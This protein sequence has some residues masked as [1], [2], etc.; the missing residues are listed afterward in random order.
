M[1]TT[2]QQVA[3][4]LPVPG[5]IWSVDREQGEIG[6]AV[7]GM[8]GLQ[9]VRGTFRSYDGSL[10]VVDGVADGHLT[11]DAASLD[12]GLA[13]RDQHLRSADFFD[14][15]RYPHIVLAA[16]AAG[17][18]EGGALVVRANL[19]VES[20]Q[21][22]LRIPIEVVQEADGGLHL[23]GEASVSREAAGLRWNKL[24]TIR[25]DAKLH[26]RL[27]LSPATRP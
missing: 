2:P 9:T 11:I 26:A 23:R 1:T 20:S 12:T 3:P 22:E 27:M 17:P 14:V 7:K 10:R 16:T 6:F 13:M 8:W 19:T 4:G 24:G 21:V 18:G 25:G 5:G 15:E